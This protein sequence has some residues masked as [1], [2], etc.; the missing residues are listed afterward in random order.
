MHELRTT[1]GGA[2]PGAEVGRQ[3]LDSET[4]FTLEEARTVVPGVQALFGFQLIVAFHP[5]FETLDWTLKGAHLAALVAIAAS[6]ALIMAPAAYHRQAERGTVSRHF[7][8]LASGL[9]AWA[10]VPLMAAVSLDIF[11][12][13][14]VV[15]PSKVL[16]VVIALG[17]AALF[18]GLWLVFPLLQRRQRYRAGGQVPRQSA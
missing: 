10:M 11:L 5:R 13:S 3:P 17:V 12:V 9:I 15:L 4:H 1:D 2:E 6:M 18:A 7:A 14:T 8:D 16:S